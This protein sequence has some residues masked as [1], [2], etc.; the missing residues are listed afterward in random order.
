MVCKLQTGGAGDGVMQE[1]RAHFVDSLAAIGLFA[2]SRVN[3]FDVWGLPIT[4]F[5]D[6]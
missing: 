3:S 5:C 4:R 6:E 2:D 1:R